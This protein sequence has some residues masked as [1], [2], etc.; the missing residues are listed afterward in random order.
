MDKGWIKLHRKITENPLYFSEP[1]TRMQAWIDMLILAAHDE[2]FFYVRGNRVNINK[3]EIGYSQE[4][5]AKR[6]KWS[7]GRVSRFIK[8]LETDGM[9]VQQKSKIITTISIANYH[10]YQHGGTT[11]DTTNST[12]DGRQTVQQTDINKNVKNDKNNIDTNVSMSNE[13]VHPTQKEGINYKNLIEFFN[14]KT[15]GVFGLVRYPISEKR[16][17]SIRAR[18]REHGKQ[19]FAEMIEKAVQ[20]D[21]LKGENS[22]GFGATFDWLIKPNNF[23]KVI[24]GNYDNRINN[25]RPKQQGN[26]ESLARSVAAGIARAKYERDKCVQ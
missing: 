26:N 23:Q 11:D 22:R 3:G 25:G 6:W 10:T 24:E 17:E 2:N 18:I 20:S 5:L 4:N 16:K 8:Q 19:A 1:F 14:E 12:T 15:N 9:I 7:R 13:Q 21:F